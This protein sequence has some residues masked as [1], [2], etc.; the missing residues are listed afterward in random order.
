MFTSEKRALKNK[1]D[2]ND[3]S[4]KLTLFLLRVVLLNEPRKRTVFRNSQNHKDRCSIVYFFLSH[5]L[6]FYANSQVNFQEQLHLDQ[7]LRFATRCQHQKN[8]DTEIA[9]RTEKGG[10]KKK[11]S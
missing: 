1:R 9:T 10:K 11:K 6:M 4:A 8:Y 2:K 7:L 3:W 5:L